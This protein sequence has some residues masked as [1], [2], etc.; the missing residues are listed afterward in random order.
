MPVVGTFGSTTFGS[1]PFAGAPGFSTTPSGIASPTATASVSAGAMENQF[2]VAAVTAAASVSASGS[3][4]AP[5]PPQ[6]VSGLINGGTPSARFVATAQASDKISVTL[7]QIWTGPSSS[8]APVLIADIT[9]YCTPGGVTWT[10]D[11]TQTPR[12]TCSVTLESQGP[13]YDD[14]TPYAQGDLLQ[15]LSGNELRIYNGYRWSDGTEELFPMGVYRMSKPQVTDDGTKVEIVITGNDRFAE[16]A[17]RGWT[18]PYVISGAPT[19]DV[20]IQ[21]LIDSVF[22]GLTYNFEP[23]TNTVPDITFGTLGQSSPVD[24]SQDAAQLA[25]ANGQEVFFDDVGI[26]V[27]RTVPNPTISAEVF[28][29]I[30]GPNCI[31]N[32]VQRVLDETQTFNGVVATSTTAGIQFPVQEIVWLSDG[33]EMDPVANPSIGYLPYYYN[34]PLFTTSAQAIVAATAMLQTLLTV[35]DDVSFQAPMYAPLR[36]GMSIEVMR[37][38][39]RIN[40]VYCASQVSGTSDVTQLM[41]VTCRAR[42]NAG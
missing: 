28:Q 38:R 34:S 41:N 30:E 27:L 42:R 19:Y 6:I 4:P 31:M 10:E 5:A 21:T 20:A 22:P 18:Q 8:A 3:V 9:E 13:D 39:A 14:L 35:L 11:E 32:E 17:K 25:I 33:S 26:C 37:S 16:V 24:P 7:V 2:A 40:D 12:W 1:A 15:P 29:F 36:A 23:T